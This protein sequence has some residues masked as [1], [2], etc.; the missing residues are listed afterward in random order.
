MPTAFQMFFFKRNRRASLL[1]IVLN[2]VLNRKK[3][4]EV[5]A[6]FCLSISSPVCLLTAGLTNMVKVALQT[7]LPS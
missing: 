1:A 6:S 2:A 4:K 7:F 5:R 3:E